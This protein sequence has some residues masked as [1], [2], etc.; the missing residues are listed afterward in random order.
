MD[1]E[2]AALVRILEFDG[3]TDFFDSIAHILMDN[4]LLPH[5]RVSFFRIDVDY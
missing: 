4:V 2:R 1:P 5:I 3:F